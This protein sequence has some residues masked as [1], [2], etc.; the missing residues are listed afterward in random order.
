M[1]AAK[2]D[3]ASQTHARGKAVI[4]LEHNNKTWQSV[5]V[6]GGELWFLLIFPDCYGFWLV[7]HLSADPRCNWTWVVS[8]V[9]S[10][11]TDIFYGP[12][13]I[14][15][16]I[17]RFPY[18]RTI[19]LLRAPNKMTL[20]SDGSFRLWMVSGCIDHPLMACFAFLARGENARFR[21]YDSFC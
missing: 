3:E 7:G 12:G 10:F 19:N 9:Y 2:P 16:N 5:S 1:S 11:C 8:F 15:N 13:C 6:G 4:T 21:C 14:K 20:H 17:D 18:R